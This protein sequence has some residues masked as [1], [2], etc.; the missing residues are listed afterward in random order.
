MTHPVRDRMLSSTD[1]NGRLAT[2]PVVVQMVNAAS[3][4]KPLR[5]IGEKVA[6]VHKDAWVPDFAPR[7]FRPN[8]APSKPHPVKDG[9]RATLSVPDHHEVANGTLR[10]LIRAAGVTV[11]AFITAA[12]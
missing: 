10:S 9:E 7:K 12:G 6:G 3:H 5:A 1:R 11:E 4:S 8:A 2:I